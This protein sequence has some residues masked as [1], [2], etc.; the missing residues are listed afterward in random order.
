VG[1]F[2]CP[3]AFS[4]NRAGEQAVLVTGEVVQR[5]ELFGQ[6][7]AVKE[8]FLSGG[9][10]DLADEQVVGLHPEYLYNRAFQVAGAFGYERRL[11]ELSRDGR[12]ACLFEL[13]E[14]APGDRADEV[15]L[16]KEV[17]AGDV[18]DELAILLYKLIGIA[19]V[20][21]DQ[22]D[23]AGLS[24]VDGR[25]PAKGH[26]VGLIHRPGGHQH[27]TARLNKPFGLVQ[28]YFLFH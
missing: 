22:Q 14:L 15:G 20:V 12:Q 21:D 3:F 16:F 19:V 9:V 23:K 26:N 7:S 11:N 28:W 6:P 27:D 2:V 24:R 5:V 1:S 13:I 10:Q 25:L 8:I 4:F 18:D 17:L